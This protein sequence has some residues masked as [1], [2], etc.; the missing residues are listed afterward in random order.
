MIHTVEVNEI[1]TPS[2]RSRATDEKPLEVSLFRM[3]LMK[4]PRSP[5]ALTPTTPLM[6]FGN[7]ILLVMA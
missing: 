7:V 2:P 5:F 4:A 3:A 1:G 6:P